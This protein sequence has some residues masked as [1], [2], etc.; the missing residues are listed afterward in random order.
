M[1]TLSRRPLPFLVASQLCDPAIVVP[2]YLASSVLTPTFWTT[3][4]REIPLNTWQRLPTALGVGFVLPTAL[5]LVFPI[6][7]PLWLLAPVL[8]PGFFFGIRF[9]N[10]RSAGLQR[11]TLIQLEGVKS[12]KY[13]VITA[14]TEQDTAYGLVLSLLAAGH[15]SVFSTL[16]FPGLCDIPGALASHAQLIILAASVVLYSLYCMLQLRRRGYISTAQMAGCFAGVLGGSVVL[17][18]AAT[19]VGTS[20][21]ADRTISGVVKAVNTPEK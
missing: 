14:G 10:R 19:Y 7:R 17:G 20:W 6:T 4:G 16:E 11:D 9:W 8:V 12:A 1:L 15:L 5:M 2:T 13:P 21:F 18:P 3:V